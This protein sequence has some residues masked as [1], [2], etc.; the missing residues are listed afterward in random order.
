MSTNR[1]SVYFEKINR[2]KRLSSGTLFE[3]DISPIKNKDI[4]FVVSN[5]PN[6]LNQY[7]YCI[8]FFNR[9]AS[10]IAQRG[11]RI[12]SYLSPILQ[13]ITT[14]LGGKKYVYLFYSSDQRFIYLLIRGSLRI[15]KDYAASH[16]YDV[17]FLLDEYQISRLSLQ[18]DKVSSITPFSI[19]HI[20]MISTFYPYEY[21]YSH[22]SPEPTIQHIYKTP[23]S[24]SNRIRLLH[25]MLHQ[26][27]PEHTSES[28]FDDFLNLNYLQNSKLINNYFPLHDD[29]D[30]NQLYDV[31]SVNSFTPWNQPFDMIKDYFGENI[32]SY[33]LFQGFLSFW[34][35]PMVLIGIGCQ[36]TAIYWNNFSRPELPIFSFLITLWI[37]LFV[38]YW[39]KFLE[40][41]K[42]KWNSYE[43]DISDYKYNL[44]NGGIGSNGN[45]DFKINENYSK[46]A[47]LHPIQIN[48]TAA[49]T[50]TNDD[51]HRYAFYG[52]R[53]PSYVHGN[54][55][56]FFNPTTRYGLYVASI[57]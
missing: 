36:I 18:G 49:T 17:Q 24:K 33:F 56:I 41:T 30:V 32:A 57:I 5:P 19:T 12:P 8:T 15:L 34:L 3:N 48:H 10:N 22:Y 25:K 11:G 46:Q 4:E 23:F 27:Q 53:I 47:F 43:K 54:E 6:N 51:M 42:L 37:I 13:K 1:N 45:N 35:I 28:G 2:S 21:I 26:Q 9:D 40:L 52:D 7:D 20:P 31:W 55:I 16:P 50:N 44:S 29:D 39:K 38:S 14:I